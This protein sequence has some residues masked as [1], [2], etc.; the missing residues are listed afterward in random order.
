MPLDWCG[1]VLGHHD[2]GIAMVE[3][4]ENIEDVVAMS[5]VCT[6]T[7]P[8]TDEAR[9]EAK[10]LAELQS[11]RKLESA[12]RKGNLRMARWFVKHLREA[13]SH[14]PFTFERACNQAARSGHVPM[15]KYLRSAGGTFTLLTCANAA[16][17]GQLA[18]L[19][20]LYANGVPFGGA[21]NL[22]PEVVDGAARAR[23]PTCLKFVLEL[24][25]RGNELAMGRAA[26]LPDATNMEILFATGLKAS[27]YSMRRAAE[28]GRLEN[29]KWLHAR[30]S[31]RCIGRGVVNAASMHGR[32]DC[33]EYAHKHGAPLDQ[34]GLHDALK[35]CC[36]WGDLDCVDY[37]VSVGAEIDFRIIN[38]A[39]EL[40]NTKF[41][42]GFVANGHQPTEVHMRAALARTELG[43]VEDR[44]WKVESGIL[45]CLRRHGVPWPE[46]MINQIIDTRYW[47]HR[48]FTTFRKAVTYGAPIT[49]RHK[50]VLCARNRHDAVRFLAEQGYS[51]DDDDGE[52]LHT[53][54]LNDSLFCVEV[55]RRMG[56][57][58]NH[59]QKIDLARRAK[60]EKKKIY[61]G[62]TYMNSAHE[63]MALGFPDTWQWRFPFW[64][65]PVGYR[66]SII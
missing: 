58:C 28:S 8:F 2:I 3:A 52:L 16:S 4:L 17:M 48:N 27:E 21:N 36:Y 41:I 12:A 20:W 32:R 37:L 11:V 33:L 65:T 14:R 30:C 59:E 34:D 50:K 7:K 45:A 43:E 46:N 51:F 47:D 66:T 62:T 55:L 22:A 42:D 23:D 57:R 56:V 13:P 40:G 26:E 31:E 53:A 24:G 64:N 5:R 10:L 29:L 39:V 60:T 25:C 6:A 63:Y 1:E 54:V 44:N 15:L 18:C 9:K 19:K 38:K 35:C 49:F 61:T